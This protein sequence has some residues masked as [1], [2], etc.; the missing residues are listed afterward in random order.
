MVA[1]PQQDEHFR[2]SERAWIMAKLGWWQDERQGLHIVLGTGSS[3]SGQTEE[4]TVFLKLTCK[5]GGRSPAWIDEVCGQL[6]IVSNVPSLR[7]ADLPTKANLCK[8][9]SMEPLGAGQ[10]ASISLELSCAGH[11]TEEKFLSAYVLLEYHDIFG[12]SRETTIGYSIDR[13]GGVYQQRALP[14]RNRNT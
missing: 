1:H 2:N 14:Q 9:G 4:T 11:A 10:E 7:N 12:I 8:C 13:R 6:D 3:P 5:N